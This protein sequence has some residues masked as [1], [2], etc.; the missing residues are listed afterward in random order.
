MTKI[1]RK[2]FTEMW[3]NGD[4]IKDVAR[5]FDITIDYVCELA[6]KLGLPKRK[7]SCGCGFFANLGNTFIHGH[8]WRKKHRSEETKVKIK[9]ALKGKHHSDETRKNVSK[10]LKKKY[11]KEKHHMCGRHLSEKIKRKIS[12]T[13]KEKYAKEEHPLLG[14]HLTEKAN[15]KRMAKKKINDEKK[16]KMGIVKVRKPF[17]AETIRRMS[18][19]Q[20]NMT[21]K[22][23][24][25]MSISKKVLWQ[26]PKYRS[27]LSGENANAWLGGISFDPYSPEFNNFLKLQIKIRDNFTCQK[28]GNIHKLGVHHIDYNKKNNNPKNIVTLCNNCN[29]EVNFNRPFWESYLKRFVVQKQTFNNL[30]GIKNEKPICNWLI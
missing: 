24:K 14:R 15:R 17:S 5:E 30:E 27:K 12:K 1:D 8:F 28:C 6:R 13:L 4:S 2:R 21:D 3:N 11:A 29:S 19:A 26:T 7:C 18:I 22:T 20:R 23:K 9:K 16:R 25:K 10:A